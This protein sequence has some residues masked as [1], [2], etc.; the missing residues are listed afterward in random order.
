[1]SARIGLLTTSYPRHERDVAG[2]FVRGFARALAERGHRI[3]VL[4]PEPRDRIA[5]LADDGIDVRWV[6]YARPRWMERTFYAAGVTDNIRRDPR[7]W[8]G[9][10]TFPLMLERAARDRV[11][12]WD[13]IVSHWALPCGLVA[14]RVRAD[15]PHLAVLHSAD[16]HLMRR[17]PLRSRWA[18]ALGEGATQLLFSSAELRSELLGWV[19]PIPRAELA[20]RS[21]VSAMG[22][23][24]LAL[25]ARRA[26]RASMNATGFVVLALGRLVPIKGIEVAL[27][28][29]AG[30]PSIEL[31]IAGDGPERDTLERH[32]RRAGARARFLGV[33]TGAR[34]AEALAAAD[35]FV[36]PSLRERSGRTEGL[37]TALLEAARAGLPIVAS[38]VGGVAELFAHD[39]N[40]LV[41]APRDARALGDALAHLRDDR[42]LRRRL[43]RA[44]RTVGR[45]YLWSELAPRIEALLFG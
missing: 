35:A 2:I 41:V 13:A 10:V 24:D 26:A 16:V 36:L 3:E 23:D 37:P 14:G 5:P 32:A 11:A 9:L 28:A 30:D 42:A 19:A 15:R 29:I 1:M 43:G 40:A 7:A 39:R 8:P 33:V 45:R 21:H 34:K 27:D 22:I 31:W 17:L 44:A 4:A 18:S 20:S 38:D 6:P 25:P 12:G